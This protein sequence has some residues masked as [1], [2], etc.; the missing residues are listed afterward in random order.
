[1]I[2]NIGKVALHPSSKIAYE[3]V[4]S[5]TLIT[6][7]SFPEQTLFRYISSI[8][9]IE[10][11]RYLT[12]QFDNCT[13]EF[14]PKFIEKSPRLYSLNIS[15]YQSWAK[16]IEIATIFSKSSIRS[17]TVHEHLL[18]LHCYERIL[19]LFYQ[20]EIVHLNIRTPDDCFRLLTILFIGDRKFHLKSLRTLTIKCDFDDPDAMAHWIQ[21]NIQRKLSYKCTTSMLTMWL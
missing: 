14:L 7:K 18:D 11:L 2:D 19:E 21:A 17:L 4:T 8:L 13:K 20:L 16:L 9:H 6:K 3:N 12:I 1:M 5:L 10:R 15:T